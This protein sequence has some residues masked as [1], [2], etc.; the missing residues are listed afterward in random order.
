MHA[1]AC[2]LCVWVYHL[3]QNLVRFIGDQCIC[4]RLAFLLV[5]GSLAVLQYLWS[6]SLFALPSGIDLSGFITTGPR[7]PYP[8]CIYKHA[9]VNCAC[10]HPHGTPSWS[11]WCGWLLV[12]AM[13]AATTETRYVDASMLKSYVHQ[14]LIRTNKPVK[15]CWAPAVVFYV[16]GL[17]VNYLHCFVIF[18]PQDK[19]RLRF[20]SGR[21][22]L[23]LASPNMAN[24]LSGS[25]IVGLF[26]LGIGQGPTRQQEKEVPWH[27]LF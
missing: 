19:V 18:P 16:T 9:A 17:C 12:Y 3:G 26:K 27:G 7:A 15:V 8:P 21:Q 24:S 13:S 1:R 2:A 4:D 5:A 20:W 11:E 10:T 6:Q 22:G 25:I 14:Q 23:K